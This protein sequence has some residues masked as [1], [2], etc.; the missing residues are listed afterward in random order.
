MTD[1]RRRR[2]E[3]RL[4]RAQEIANALRQQQAELAAALRDVTQR[5]RTEPVVLAEWRRAHASASWSFPDDA[6]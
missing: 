2:D 6:G 1:D 5:S 3:E 4:R